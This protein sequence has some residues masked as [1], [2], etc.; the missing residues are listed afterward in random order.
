[1]H[2]LVVEDDPAI[3]HLI[4]LAVADEGWTVVVAADGEAALERVKR[5]LSM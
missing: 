5:P 1:M 3:R 2:V 4:S